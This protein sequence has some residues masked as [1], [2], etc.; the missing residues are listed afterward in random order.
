MIIKYID[1]NKI[2]YFDNI[3]KEDVYSIEKSYDINK[4]IEY[5]VNR[6]SNIHKDLLSIINY[7]IQ[8]NKLNPNNRQLNKIKF[9]ISK[10]KYIEF[11]EL[12]FNSFSYIIPNSFF[13]D[14][15]IDYPIKFNLT[16]YSFKKVLYKG[17]LNDC[18]DYINKKDFK[19]NLILKPFHIIYNTDNIFYNILVYN[20][21]IYKN[22]KKIKV[23]DSY[24]IKKDRN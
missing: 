22:I 7:I 19:Y 8:L 11:I 3:S 2:K 13:N 9:H 16:K 10:D 5:N 20:Y 18:I 15:E 23:N 4:I 1:I 14:N 24:K 21:S 17:K 6:K 12:F